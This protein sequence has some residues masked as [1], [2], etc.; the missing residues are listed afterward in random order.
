LINAGTVL[1]IDT[2]NVKSAA[3][4]AIRLNSSAPGGVEQMYRVFDTD[5]ANETVT[6]QRGDEWLFRI[7]CKKKK[8]QKNQKHCV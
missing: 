3:V 1:Q 4:A 6:K 2:F 8:N 7:A 5:G